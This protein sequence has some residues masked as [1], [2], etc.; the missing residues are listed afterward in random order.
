MG[1]ER[2]RPG[3]AVWNARGEGTNHGPEA[4]GVTYDLWGARTLK[5][6]WTTGHMNEWGSQ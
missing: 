3:N 6:A 5:P 4:N 2:V 1:A